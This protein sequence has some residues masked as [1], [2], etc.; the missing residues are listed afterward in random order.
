M[1]KDYQELK[2]V[3][4]RAYIRAS[5]GKGKERH[6]SDNTPF[7][8]QQIVQDLKEMKTAAPACFQIRKKALEA[9]RLDDKAAIG[10]LLDIIVYASAAVIYYD[11]KGR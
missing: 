3:L 9:L 11:M 8:E 6:A 7:E 1:E 4:D 5:E 2:F 10:E